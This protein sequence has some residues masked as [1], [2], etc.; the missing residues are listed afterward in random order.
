M[1]ESSSSRTPKYTVFLAVLGIHLALLAWIVTASRTAQVG[2][3][4]SSPVQV[5]FI[6]PP[7]APRVRPENLRPERL[8]SNIMQGLSPPVL[9]SAPEAGPG[10]APDGR[11]SAPNWT[12]EAHRAVRAF[13]IRRDRP[14]DTPMAAASPWDGWWPRWGHHAGDRYK[15]ESGDW[16]VWIDSNCYQIANWHADATVANNSPPRTVCLADGEKPPTAE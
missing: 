7:K 16:I 14:P 9:N 2:A 10:S 11:G 3:A 4:T 15:T 12:A 5:F 6:T 13:E 8:S 1:G